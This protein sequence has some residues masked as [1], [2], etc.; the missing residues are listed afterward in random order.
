MI[1]ASLK[2]GAFENC[3]V[4]KKHKYSHNDVIDGNVN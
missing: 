1:G 2:R 3:K 4:L